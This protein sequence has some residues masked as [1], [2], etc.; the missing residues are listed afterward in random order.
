MPVVPH[1][2]RLPLRIR[3]PELR[4]VPVE[5]GAQAAE[6]LWDCLLPRIA[7]DDHVPQADQAVAHP[8]EPLA[9]GDVGLLHQ[10][11][12]FSGSV[13]SRSPNRAG[14]WHPRAVAT[15]LAELAFPTNDVTAA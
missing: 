12:R 8:I 6:E 10:Q 11:Q 13:S 9:S 7:A 14:D 15:Q 1:V 4:D 2:Q 3:R 5:E